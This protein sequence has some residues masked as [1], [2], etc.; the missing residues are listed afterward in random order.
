MN[1][2]RMGAAVA[3]KTEPQ[4]RMSM[5]RTNELLSNSITAM[6]NVLN[7]TRDC[8]ASDEVTP[9]PPIETIMARADELGRKAQVLAKMISELEQYI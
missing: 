3:A 2:Q 8:P 5:Q 4:V 7:R 9:M 1:E 6:N